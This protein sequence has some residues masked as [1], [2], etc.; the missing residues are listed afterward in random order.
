VLPTVNAPWDE[1]KGNMKSKYI[2]YIGIL[3]LVAG[4]LLRY[5]SPYVEVGLGLVLIGVILKLSYV[6]LAMLRGKYKPKAEILLLLFGLGFLFLGLWHKLNVS[7][8]VGYGMIVSAVVLKLIFVI[9]FIRKIRQGK[10][11]VKP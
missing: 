4:I 11:S 6:S 2:L 5:F 8:F 1:V 3:L 9:L 7:E 10:S